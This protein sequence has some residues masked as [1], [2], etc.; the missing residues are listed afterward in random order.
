MQQLWGQCECD[1][2]DLL[3]KDK[4]HFASQLHHLLGG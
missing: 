2:N 1:M 4:P 3:R